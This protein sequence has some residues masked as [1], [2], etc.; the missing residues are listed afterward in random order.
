MY[1]TKFCRPLAET[2]K[3]GGSVVDALQ[4]YVNAKPHQDMFTTIDFRLDLMR[5]TVLNDADRPGLAFMF[6]KSR[7]RNIVAAK[8]LK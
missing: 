7:V 6:H 8:L 4:N 2:T 5:L 1:S 3:E